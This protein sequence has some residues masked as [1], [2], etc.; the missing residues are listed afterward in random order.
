MAAFVA[1]QMLGSKMNAVKGER[2]RADTRIYTARE[3][4]SRRKVLGARESHPAR[5]R[6]NLR[7]AFQA[8]CLTIGGRRIFSLSRHFDSSFFFIYMMGR[9]DKSIL[10]LSFGPR[11]QL[12]CRRPY[13]EKESCYW[14]VC[15]GHHSAAAAAAL[16]KGGTMV[17][18]T[19]SGI[20]NEHYY[21]QQWRKEGRV[22]REE[23]G[24]R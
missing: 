3:K 12:L 23:A 5:A 15:V 20:V 1:K 2:P 18:H 14:S 8:L 22:G 16:T 7:A 24:W 21:T 4:Q 11:D 13:K 9:R 19:N 6:G 17:A 10:F